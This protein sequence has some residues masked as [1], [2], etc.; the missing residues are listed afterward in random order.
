MNKK[1]KIIKPKKKFNWSKV[2]SY[3]RCLWSNQVTTEFGI[4][5]KWYV[6][7]IVALLSI[8]ISLIPTTV[9]T[10]TARG[11]SFLNTTSYY[12][13][14]EGIYSFLEDAK[15]NNYDITFDKKTGESKLVGKTTSSS[16]DFLLYE[17]KI[18]KSDGAKFVDLQ[19]YYIDSTNLSDAE[20]SAAITSAYEEKPNSL[21]GRD[22]SFL[23]FTT[24]TF[25]TRIY[26][27]KSY[28]AVSGVYGDFYNLNDSLTN[29]FV[30][31]LY[32]ND[33]T[34]TRLENISSSLSE[35]K[36][37]LDDVYINT[38]KTVTLTQVGIIAA[39]NSGIVLLMGLVLFL[40][41]RGKN[42][43]Q[44]TVKFQECFNIAYW[45]TISPA[46]ISLILGFIISAYQVMLFVIV[47]GFRVMWLSMKTLSPNNPPVKK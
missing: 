5:K 45:S 4:T 34:K 40:L 33:S 42:N 19:V 27:P 41:T 30:D 14:D 13:Y 32:K 10:A 43:P 22:A 38:R 23:L 1:A 21:D 11:S 16:N 15:K 3:L 24:K 44:R 18:T 17:H 31:A 6:A 37:F 25:V 28:V 26:K 39:I 29:G 36:L 7:V 35:Y 8:I 47:F 12:N 20:L 46:L 2:I 9:S